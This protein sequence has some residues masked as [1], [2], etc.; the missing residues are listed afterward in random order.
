[1]DNDNANN[2]NSNVIILIGIF[3]FT[4]LLVGVVT[5]IIIL[6][7]PKKETTEF[8]AC[9]DQK[10][11]QNGL[12]CSLS[13]IDNTTKCLTGL[14]QPCNVDGDCAQPFSCLQ[15]TDT[16]QLLCMV[17]PL[18][19]SNTTTNN[20]TLNTIPIVS[21]PL[22]FEAPKI[23]NTPNINFVPRCTYNNNIYTTL[24]QKKSLFKPINYCNKNPVKTIKNEC[25]SESSSDLEINSCGEYEDLPFDVESGASTEESECQIPEKIEHTQNYNNLLNVVDCCN[26]SE[27]ALFLNK[28]GIIISF[29]FKNYRVINCNRYLI[30]IFTFNDDLYGIDK[31][32]KIYMLSL[33]YYDSCYWAF[34]PV[35][36]APKNVIHFS[37][38]LDDKYLWLQTPKKCYLIDCDYKK[39]KYN[40]IKYKRVYGKNKHT[41]LDIN[42]KK[43]LCH[44][45]IN[46]KKVETLHEIHAGIIDH[47]N[48]VIL[49]TIQD[50]NLYNNIRLIDYNPYYIDR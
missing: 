11:C 19:T 24:Q 8:G 28:D 1:M 30:H 10:D 22:I 9:T 18:D 17:N 2:N 7:L 40:N 46:T 37:T 33:K 3:L 43:Q 21:Q 27:E 5:L 36:W 23:I 29:K 16:K 6:A 50:C 15:N 4:I 31:Y 12:V 20:N 47:A 26:Y 48:N 41:Y 39:I 42:I 14:N 32:N 49:I 45:I 44:V 35:K 34:Y 25:L 38:T 13:K